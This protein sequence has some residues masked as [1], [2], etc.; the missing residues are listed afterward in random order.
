VL[1][2]SS[3]SKKVWPNPDVQRRVNGTTEMNNISYTN[4]E[5]II[6]N[7][8]TTNHFKNYEISDYILSN[9]SELSLDNINI[10][11]PFIKINNTKM[12][13]TFILL[14]LI[15]IYLIFL[16]IINY[17]H[18]ILFV[19]KKQRPEL[20]KPINQENFL[21]ELRD[22]LNEFH[23]EPGRSILEGGELSNP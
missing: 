10:L 14:I 11:N 13:L 15:I 20:E 6:L 5:N 9:N 3:K 21:T 12:S 4:L 18:V 1:N 8:L 2:L 22:Q 7:Y 19:T 16:L 23:V 17:K